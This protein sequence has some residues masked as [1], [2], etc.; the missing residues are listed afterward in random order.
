MLALCLN[1]SLEFSF[2][3]GQKAGKYCSN[4]CQAEWQYQ[5]TIKHWLLGRRGEL[6]KN[7]LHRYLSEQK[8]GCWECG[9]E[10][11]RGV[12]LSLEADHIDGNNSNNRPSN[13]RHLCPNCHSIT[14]TF[15][16]KNR[17]KGRVARKKRDRERLKFLRS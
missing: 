6:S 16:G 8:Q 15:K 12:K 11:W 14:P 3:T 17:G 2:R 5:N 1:C 7:T 13:F 10:E 4:K 9:L